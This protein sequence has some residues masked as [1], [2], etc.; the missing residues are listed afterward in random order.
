MIME[1]SVFGA[2]QIDRPNFWRGID[3]IDWEKTSSGATPKKLGTFERYE[4]DS[5]LGTAVTHTDE[6]TSV[7]KFEFSKL[8]VSTLQKPDPIG[9]TVIN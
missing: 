1:I 3:H 5:Q 9:S 7:E 2:G 6:R 4:S 8:P